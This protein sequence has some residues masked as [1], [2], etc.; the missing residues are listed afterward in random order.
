MSRNVDLVDDGDD[1]PVLAHSNIVAAGD[2]LRTDGI[3]VTIA[4]S[5]RREDSIGNCNSYGEKE[6]VSIE[7]SYSGIDLNFEP[8][9]LGGVLT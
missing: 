2:I 4:N 6:V 1:Y 3:M 9:D 5:A 8:L 7:L